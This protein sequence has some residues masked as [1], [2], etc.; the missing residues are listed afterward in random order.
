MLDFDIVRGFWFP[1]VGLPPP[2]LTTSLTSP[3]TSTSRVTP[4]FDVWGSTCL[5]WSPTTGNTLVQSNYSFPPSHLRCSLGWRCITGHQTWIR[6]CSRCTKSSSLG[7][8]SVWRTWRSEGCRKEISWHEKPGR[9]W[10]PV[11]MI[12]SPLHLRFFFVR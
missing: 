11:L 1:T 2:E 8:R 10:Q 4:P 3:N 6:C 7:R 5:Q 12:F 9:W